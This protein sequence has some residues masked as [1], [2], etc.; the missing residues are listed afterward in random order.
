MKRARLSLEEK[1]KIL[2]YSNEIQKSCEEIADQFQIGNTA[3]SI[4]K[5][6]KKLRKEIEFFKCNWKTKHAG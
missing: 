3:A 6:G 5:D 4:L 2:N 1:I